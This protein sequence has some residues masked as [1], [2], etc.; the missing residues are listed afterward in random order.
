MLI[1]TLSL[2]LFS[3][4]AFAAPT[5]PVLTY[6]TYLRD[7]FTPQ[8]IATDA[9]GNIYLAGN[10][11][12]DPAT[13][14]STVLV[15]K[16]NPQASQYLYVR[17]LG[18]SVKDAANAIAVDAAG[19]AY[20]A[21]STASPDFPVTSGGNLGTAPRGLSNQRS[22][23]IKLDP[24]GEIVF[25][26]L[27]GGSAGSAAQAVAV[28]AAGRI[29]VTGLVSDAAGPAFPSTAGAYRIANTANHPYLLELEPT[30]TKIVFSATGIG[31][32]ALA[33]DASGNIYVAGSTSLLDYPTTPGAYQS[34]FPAFTIC[35]APPCSGTFQGANQYVTKVDPTGSTLLYSTAVSGKG[36][37]TN[38]GLAVDAAGNVY[39]TGYAGP[40]YPYTVTPPAIPIG[41][42][43][44]IFFFELPFLSKLDPAGKT[45]LFSVPVGGAGVQVDS[46]G[47]YVSG[48]AGS[49]LAGSY[50]IANNL[51]ALANVPTP[52]LP[53]HLGIRSSAYVSE[54]DAASGDLLG[55]QFIGGSTLATSALALFGSTAWI[56]GAATLPDFP[57][58]P[59][60]VT[61]PSLRPAPLAGAYLGAVDFS[62]PPPPAGTPQLF[63]IVDSADLA[64]VGAAPCYQLL[65]IFGTGLGPAAGV[66]ASDNSTAT[67]AGVS[68]N[69][70]S[71]SAPL[72]YVSS[73]QIN[74]AVPLV[75]PSQTFATMQV[76]VNG[77][78]ATPRQLPLTLSGNPSLFL[79][80][81]QTPVASL[82][83]VALALNADGSLNSST[84]PAALGSAVSVFVNGLTPD[85]RFIHFPL[86][87]S[88]NNG[89]SVTGL[90]P[91]NPF[92]LRVDL[93][94]PS[95]LVNNFSC[96][97]SSL[98][99][100][101]FTL[102]DVGFVSV[103]EIV[104][105]GVAFG[106]VVYANRTP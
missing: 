16:L 76:T 65:T 64:P 62:Q 77:A 46:H 27:L 14:Q 33:L 48:G 2:I 31:G 58:T 39:L 9:S 98:C 11:I 94:V 51:P 19:N 21:G 35:S 25:S 1:Y 88:T 34:T 87:L 6:S 29:V 42:V 36:N 97:I 63:C 28:N 53:N 15:V 47:V 82:G 75:D 93:R 5:F 54:I 57:L 37:T 85:P 69:L 71:L 92:V 24:S 91:A 20:V 83:S 84:N 45:L 43:N 102:Y 13:S 81:A 73:T 66:A 41:P 49:G 67:L 105:G 32:S 59:N 74:F 68:V 80:T 61:L 44:S 60:A 22:F 7:S 100:V 4:L 18:G 56:A 95:A 72:L 86:Q 79:N 90:V 3:G 10:A 38:G 89:W 104:S 8:A 106:G 12:V 52:C 23:V 40:T 17:Y 70:D 99:A 30:G 55:S 50:G 96:A 101:G 103:G 26:D 78:S